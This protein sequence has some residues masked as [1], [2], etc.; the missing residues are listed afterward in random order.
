MWWIFAVV[1]CVIGACLLALMLIEEKRDRKQFEKLMQSYR[2]L[3][4]NIMDEYESTIDL[5]EEL[6]NENEHL[7][8]VE[9]ILSEELDGKE[10]TLSEKEKR[11]TELEEAN[12]E[13]CKQLRD[14]FGVA[15]G[16]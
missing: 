4:T 15:E 6:G 1:L 8:D 5:I 3:A 11:I 7:H 16:A 13:L 10:V 14:L 12:E 9:M 2:T